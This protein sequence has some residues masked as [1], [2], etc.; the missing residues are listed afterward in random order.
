MH[1]LLT[2]ASQTTYS[3]LIRYVLKTTYSCLTNNF[4]LEDVQ[5]KL[6]HLN[7]CKSTGPDLL[8][9]RVLRTLEHM[10]GGRQNH[11]INKSA[12]TRIISADWKSDNVTAIHKKGN[13][14]EPGNYRPI[15]LASVVF[16]AMER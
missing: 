3:C 9:P 2:A 12:K 5:N 8:H 16:K 1:T 11:I 13:R 6:N 14:Q 7:V 4:R 10:L 15:S